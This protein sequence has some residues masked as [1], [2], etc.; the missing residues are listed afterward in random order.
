MRILVIH[1]SMRKGNTYALTK[2]ITS[3]LSAKLDVKISEISVADIDLPFCTSCHVCFS[4]GEEFCPNQKN[5]Q[6]IRDGLLDCDGVIIT[7]TTYVWALNAAMKNVLDHFAYM[8]HRPALFGK[9]GLILVTSA[10]NNEKAIAKYIKTVIGQMGINKAMIFTQNTKQKLMASD[11]ALN[12]KYDKIA[13]AFYI[14]VK[15]KR[16]VSPSLKSIAKHN[17]FRAML[18]SEFSDYPRDTEYWK[19]PS[20]GGSAYPVKIN[21]FTRFIGAMVFYIK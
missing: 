8:F 17:A 10:G 13:D 15:L 5:I 3:R 11:A 2:E 19:E 12:Q 9:H 4:K 16:Q 21:F 18:Q 6:G 7:G 1:G 20:N 14:R